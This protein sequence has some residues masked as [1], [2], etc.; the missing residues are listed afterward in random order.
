MPLSA[1][2]TGE[3]L[4]ILGREL[5][6]TFWPMGRTT[7]RY[8]VQ[9]R[10]FST[11]P[12]PT[13]VRSIQRSCPALSKQSALAF[14]EQAQDYYRAATSGD[15]SAAKPLLLYYS[16]MNLAKAYILHTGQRPSL[17]INSK[18]GISEKLTPGGVELTGA[19]LE[20]F[21]S[22]NVPAAAARPARIS[23]NLFH[24]FLSI[25]R[26][27][28]LAAATTFHL[29]ALLPQV[30]AGHRLWADGANEKE[31]FIAFHRIS[32]VED[33]ATKA[34][35][36]RLFVFSDDF[37]R[38]NLSHQQFLRA[39]KLNTEFHEV[40]CTEQVDN[41]SLVC[42]EQRNPLLYTHRAADSVPRLVD[43]I[44]PKIWTVVM[45][46]PPYRRYYAYLAPVDDHPLV[47]PQLQAIYAIA[48]Y[49]G[50]ITRY[51]PHHFR[52]ITDSNFGPFIEAFLNDQPPQFLY[53]MASEFAKQDITRAAIV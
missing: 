45:S 28:G 10:I 34:I 43:L 5:P 40:Q 42:F 25:S 48:Y 37:S 30:L 33:R 24:E 16:F 39:G 35:W 50:S 49:L 23:I 9:F 29:P 20:T 18:H 19:F 17:D 2:R 44:R 12:W 47:I 53:L 21:P 51:R 4:K 41:R 52:K 36:L 7:R 22:V 13:I 3:Q 27:G 6:F 11:N 8:G 15:V 46:Q 32:F 14:V 26:P 1:P 31:R 38:L